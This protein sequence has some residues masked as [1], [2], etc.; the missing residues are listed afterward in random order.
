MIAPP[1]KYFA[2]EAELMTFKGIV[3]VD[4][5]LDISVRFL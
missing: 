1:K 4:P 3:V 2:G 5:R